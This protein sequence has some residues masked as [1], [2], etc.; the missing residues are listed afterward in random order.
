MVIIVDVM[1]V[2][3]ILLSTVGVPLIFK[4]LNFC[5]DFRTHVLNNFF[6]LCFPP[7][8]GEL[9]EKA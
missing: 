1:V 3:R 7:R 8:K 9:E 2:K 5:K 4:M 6:Q